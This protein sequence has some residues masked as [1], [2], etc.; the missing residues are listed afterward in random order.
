MSMVKTEYR[1]GD[2]GIC[3]YCNYQIPL[4]LDSL[5]NCKNCISREPLMQFLLEIRNGE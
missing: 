5:D 3:N 2:F 1:K 4:S